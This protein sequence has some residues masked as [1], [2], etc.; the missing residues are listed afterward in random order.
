[1]KIK[2]IATDC[3]KILEKTHLIKDHYPKD[4]KKHLKLNSKKTTQ[5]KN[6]T[7]QPPLQWQMSI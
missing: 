5:L 4:I 2:R 3:K 1:M 7:K 6:K